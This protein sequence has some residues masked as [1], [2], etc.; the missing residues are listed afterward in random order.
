MLR[1][2]R[3]LDAGRCSGFAVRAGVGMVRV[4]LDQDEPPVW[5]ARTDIVDLHGYPVLGAPYPGAKVLVG[6]AAQRDAEH[7]AAVINLIADREHGQAE[8]AV[9]GE[10]ANAL[11]GDEPPALGGVQPLY[12]RIPDRRVGGCG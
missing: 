5:T 6:R 1:A 4:T 9:V 8:L 7:E 12:L 2:S 3:R 10:S 11:G